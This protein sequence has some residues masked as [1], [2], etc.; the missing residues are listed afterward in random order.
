[1]GKH[2]SERI[3][4]CTT[5]TSLQNLEKL[6]GKEGEIKFYSDQPFSA[7][8]RFMLGMYFLDISHNKMAGKM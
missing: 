5:K 2:Y 1:L 8:L 6:K 4:V 3:D 7:H